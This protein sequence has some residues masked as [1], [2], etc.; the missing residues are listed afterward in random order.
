MFSVQLL[1]QNACY[2]ISA[3][4]E[5]HIVRVPGTDGNSI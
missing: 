4:N 5:I 1:S 2:E 3:R